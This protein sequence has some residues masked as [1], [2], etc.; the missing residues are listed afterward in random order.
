MADLEKLEALYQKECVAMKRHADKA[1]DLK[2]QIEIARGDRILRAVKQLN[3]NSLQFGALEKL[4][5]NKSIVEIMEK[6][7]VE[8]EKGGNG[9][10][11]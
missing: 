10:E 2:E 3:L 7:G 8:S 11:D 5:K 6:T 1:K 9:E 4:L